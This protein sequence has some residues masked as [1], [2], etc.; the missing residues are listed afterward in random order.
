MKADSIYCSY[1]SPNEGAIFSQAANG[2]NIK[3]RDGTQSK[4]PHVQLNPLVPIV[5]P[6]SLVYVND[7]RFSAAANSLELVFAR[8]LNFNRPRKRPPLIGENAKVMSFA[9]STA[10]RI[11]KEM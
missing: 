1:S 8:T 9:R 10:R 6:I 3:R 4:I 2:P 5:P 7:A 11:H